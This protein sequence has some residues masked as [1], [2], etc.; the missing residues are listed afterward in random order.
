MKNLLLSLTLC[1]CLPGLVAAQVTTATLT[2]ELTPSAEVPP[3]STDAS[4]TAVIAI[5]QI[6]TADGALE[7]AI[8]DFRIMWA[9]GQPETV[10]ALHIH[11]GAAGSNG[12]VVI[13]AGFGDPADVPAGSGSFLRS[14]G[15]IS[16]PMQLEAVEAIL[17]NPGG[18]YVNLH[19][20]SNPGGIIRGNLRRANSMMLMMTLN[21][22][23]AVEASDAAQDEELALIKANVEAIARRLGIVPAQ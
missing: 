17:A 15:V 11:R 10:R 4:G 18:Y 22:L 2:T 13:N 21:K 1:A 9:F 12:G 16:D 7:G 20:A 19:T 23:N 3:V 5:H 6:R 14:T 8:V